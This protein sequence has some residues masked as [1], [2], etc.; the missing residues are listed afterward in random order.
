[1]ALVD[2]PQT[3][4]SVL[5]TMLSAVRPGGVAIV[6]VLNAWSLPDGQPVWQRSVRRSVG[7]GEVIIVKGVQRI[8]ASARVNLLVIPPDSPEQFRAESVP[9][10]ALR[11]DDLITAASAAGAS[12]QLFGS[13]KGVPYDPATSVDLT[14]VAHRSSIPS[15]GAD[16]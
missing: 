1:L 3:A 12:T 5:G 6:H 14:L 10:L 16:L 2:S 8:G 7:G 11:A 4:A 9:F 15:S 13:V